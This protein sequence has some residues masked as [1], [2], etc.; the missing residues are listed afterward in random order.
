MLSQLDLGRGNYQ[1]AADGYASALALDSSSLE[2]SFGLAFSLGK[3]GRFEESDSLAG[4]IKSELER[5]GLTDSPWMVGFYLMRS[6]V[7]LERG[8]LEEARNACEQALVNATT[9][10]RGS[11]FRQLAEISLSAKQT[12][13]GFL[14]CEE[15]LSVN[16]NAPLTLLTLARLYHA[17]G[18]Q[19]MTLEIGNRLLEMWKDADADFIYL[20]QLRQ[21]LSTGHTA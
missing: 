18:E 14:E 6:R 21:L 3:M 16:P 4:T 11:I 7:L 9:I 20:K 8:M 10:V 2:S 13:R 1:D 19:R 17:N 15:S 5:K 12:E